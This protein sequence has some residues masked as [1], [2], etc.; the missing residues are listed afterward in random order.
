MGESTQALTLEFG[1]EAEATSA[2]EQRAWGRLVSL[3]EHSGNISLQGIYSF[4]LFAF[5]FIFP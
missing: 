4:F 5:L 2:G 3:S 1:E